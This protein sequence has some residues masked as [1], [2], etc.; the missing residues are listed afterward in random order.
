MSTSAARSPSAADRI[1]ALQRSRAESST[2]TLAPPTDLRGAPD[3]AV[4]RNPT[5]WLAVATVVLWALGFFAL[6]VLHWAVCLLL[7]LYA[8]MMLIAIALGTLMS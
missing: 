7:F 5:M 2:T 3:L 8:P 1:A 4:H 6:S